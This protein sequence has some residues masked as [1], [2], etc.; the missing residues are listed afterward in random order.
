MYTHHDLVMLKKNNLFGVQLA[1]TLWG[2]T[3]HGTCNMW[4]TSYSAVSVSVTQKGC[5]SNS[6]MPY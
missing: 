6:Q 1:K 2:V 5:V 3:S 4:V